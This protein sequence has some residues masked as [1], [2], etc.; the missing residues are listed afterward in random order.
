M[1]GELPASVR[2]RR[3]TILHQPKLLSSSRVKWCCSVC[4]PICSDHS[5]TQLVREVSLTSPLLDGI[6]LLPYTPTDDSCCSLGTAIN[7]HPR[8][9]ARRSTQ[10]V[11]N[12]HGPVYTGALDHQRITVLVYFQA[13]DERVCP[14]TTLVT[15]KGKATSPRSSLFF[16]ISYT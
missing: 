12:T 5:V 6:S 15:M 16:T 11:L 2:K 14:T 10:I 8:T 7:L 1:R 13:A 3:N 9:A 4:L